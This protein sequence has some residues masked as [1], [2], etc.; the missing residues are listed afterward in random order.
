MGEREENKKRETHLTLN[1]KLN[2]KKTK[3]KASITLLT[4]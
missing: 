1:V 3:E 2:L 4:Q